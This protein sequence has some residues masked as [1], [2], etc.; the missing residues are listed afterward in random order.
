MNATTIEAPRNAVATRPPVVPHTDISRGAGQ[1]GIRNQKVMLATEVL[2]DYR[3]IDCSLGY[4]TAG[5][6]LSVLARHIAAAPGGGRDDSFA[7]C[8]HRQEDH[9]DVEVHLTVS[10][11]R[12]AGQECLIVYKLADRE[13]Q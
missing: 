13:I 11:S 4:N 10:R 7:V 6:I 1:F 2:D 3:E 12:R 5:M 9:H 8:L